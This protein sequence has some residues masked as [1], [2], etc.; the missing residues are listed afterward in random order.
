MALYATFTFCF[1]AAFGGMVGAIC[2]CPSVDAK[3]S[4]WWHVLVTAILFAPTYGPAR[5]ISILQQTTKLS[6]LIAGIIFALL[7]VTVLVHSLFAVRG[8]IHKAASLAIGFG[9]G[10][11]ASRL[12]VMVFGNLT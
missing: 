6:H 2:L 12:L 4:S 10:W 11:G 1:F 7:F 5:Y 9:I 8:W 3:T